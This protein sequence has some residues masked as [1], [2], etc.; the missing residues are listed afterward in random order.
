M[1]LD[2]PSA[3]PARV[4]IFALDG[5][6]VRTLLDAPTTA[7]RHHLTWDGRDR[8]GNPAPAGVYFYRLST[9]RAQ[10]TG[11]LILAR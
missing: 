9:D 3:G 5:S 2:L 7:G 1:Q 4:E 11:K 8:A 10:P 6:L